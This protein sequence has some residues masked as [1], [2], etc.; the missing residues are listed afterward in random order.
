MNR[1]GAFGEEEKIDW[2][3]FNFTETVNEHSRFDDHLNVIQWSFYNRFH[4]NTNTN[5]DSGTSKKNTELNRNKQKTAKA[6][7]F[8]ISFTLSLRL[9]VAD[10]IRFDQL[11]HSTKLSHTVNLSTLFAVL[12]LMTHD[13]ILHVQ[14]PNCNSPGFNCC[15]LPSSHCNSTVRCGCFFFLLQLKNAWIEHV[16][17][18]DHLFKIMHQICKSFS[19]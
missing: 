7:I 4:R 16:S 6:T 19:N 11:T 15:D 12:I 14:S 5:S 3:R 8:F 1:N 10:S 18:I 2:E 13:W 17:Q 9:T